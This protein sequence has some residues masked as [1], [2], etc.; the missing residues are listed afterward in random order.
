MKNLTILLTLIIVLFSCTKKKEIDNII[1]LTL[2]TDPNITNLSELGSEIM[3]FPLETNENCFIQRIEKLIY[4]GESYYLK[5]GVD[6]TRLRDQ[7]TPGIPVIVGPKTELFRFSKNGE[8]ICQIGRSGRA[9][10]EYR[11]IVNL[12]YNESNNTIGIYTL[13]D[14]KE[15]S[16]E[17]KWKF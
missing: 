7:S 3:Y 13:R 9:P 4:S 10:S 14:I 15:Y 16:L 12:M 6:I 8:F 17:G 2:I 1:D 11:Y 5:S